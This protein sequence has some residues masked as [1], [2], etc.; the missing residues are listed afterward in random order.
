MKRNLVLVTL[1]VA[2]A[3]ATGLVARREKGGGPAAPPDVRNR[4]G[5]RGQE[6]SL[7]SGRPGGGEAPDTWVDVGAPRDGDAP[8]KTLPAELL[9]A[10]PLPVPSVPEP[11]PVT[12]PP[13]PSVDPGA[14]EDARAG[15]AAADS[16]AS[17][18]LSEA[19][20][21]SGASPIRNDAPLVPPV[22]LKAAW[23]TYPRDALKRKVQA[24]VEVRILVAETGGVAQVEL[25]EAGADPAL[26]RAA[27]ES[28]R[29]MKFR[30]ATRGG[31]PVAV[32]YNYRFD[33]ALPRSS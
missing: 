28:A 3:L 25:I 6:D 12:P 23:L 16:T 2:G 10:R 24:N 4:D 31:V 19:D 32:W 14:G 5:L 11:P 20:D 1:L 27:I 13:A 9:P 17:A 8:G 33:F 21:P 22:L 26:A 7:A 15:G 30:P 18:S 29:S